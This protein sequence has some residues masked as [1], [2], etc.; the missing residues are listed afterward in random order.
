M[1]ARKLTM[2][3]EMNSEDFADARDEEATGE[4]SE[5]Q[6]KSGLESLA[7]A[8][9]AGLSTSEAAAD[10]DAR[11]S[12]R[13][14]AP[15]RDL[16][17]QPGNHGLPP[18]ASFVYPWPSPS[19][20][21]AR[22][23]PA[24]DRPART[25][26][27]STETSR[28]AILDQYGGG[29]YQSWNPYPHYPPYKAAGPYQSWNPY[30]YDQPYHPA[31]PYLP[32]RSY[33]AP[34]APYPSY[35]TVVEQR[36]RPFGANSQ[37]RRPDL[38][39][40][41]RRPR[42]T[43]ADA[44]R[45][46]DSSPAYYTCDEDDDSDDRRERR[47]HVSFSERSCDG[48]QMD[49]NSRSR[50]A[51]STAK[52]RERPVSSADR[53]LSSTSDASDV[54]DL[55]RQSI[56]NSVAQGNVSTPKPYVKL[57]TYDGT[58]CLETFLAKFDNMANYLKWSDADRLFHLKASLEGSAGQI[59]WD[60]GPQTTFLGVV[61]ILRA[62]FG[63]ELQAERFRAEL[64]ARRRK[65]GETLQNLYQDICKLLA[66]AYPGQSNTAVGIIGRDAFLDALSDP[67]MRV[68]VLEREPK[69]L[70]EALNYASKFEAF[71]RSSGVDRPLSSDSFDGVDRNRSRNVRGIATSGSDQYDVDD[72]RHTVVALQRQ[73]D[74]VQFQQ[75]QMQTTVSNPFY[76]HGSYP[77]DQNIS[78]YAVSQPQTPTSNPNW[79]MG[80]PAKGASKPEN[81]G[82]QMV[83]QVPNKESG[84]GF[85]SR[86]GPKD[87]DHCHRC[88]EVGHWSRDCPRRK[89]TV[90]STTNNSSCNVISGNISPAELYVNAKIG[91]RQILCLFDTGCEHSVVG[92]KLVSTSVFEPSDVKLFAANGTSMPVLGSL[93]L[94]FT[95][96]GH[97]V[98]A[99]LLV[100]DAVEELIIGIDWLSSH[101]CV[102]DFGLG[103]VRLQG[104]EVKL[105]HRKQKPCI[106]RIYVEEECVIHPKH[107]SKIQVRTTWSTLRAPKTDWQFKPRQMSKK[108]VVARRLL[109]GDD[110]HATIRVTNYGNTPFTIRRNRYVGSA[111]PVGA[112]VDTDGSPVS[113]PKTAS[114]TVSDMKTVRR[115][116]AVSSSE[117]VPD[118]ETVSGSETVRGDD[119]VLSSK[120]VR[121]A[122]AVSISR[123]VRD[124]DTGS[125]LQ[126]RS[127]VSVPRTVRDAQTVSGS[128]TARVRR[129]PKLTTPDIESAFSGSAG[130]QEVTAVSIA[131]DS[132]VSPDAQSAS[133]HVPKVALWEKMG[134]G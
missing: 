28:T 121:H 39:T 89:G 130:G 91:N 72:L 123:T 69:T 33:S 79:A 77:H 37:D 106:R 107:H 133:H 58:K 93:R 129:L 75:Q 30:P 40:E 15:R 17:Q 134:V 7:E 104:Y 11:G 86:G 122:D 84:I 35:Y 29:P 94:N 5:M 111:E 90:T 101:G 50:R 8:A 13:L 78:Q 96:E 63:N 116:D 92:R 83:N 56:A 114:N 16:L 18:G 98:T 125:S 87:T 102:W 112:L 44:T 61:Q 88:K 10:S 95:L 51:Y 26:T 100:S 53:E 117:T 80:T 24:A 132:G 67:N 22:S 126:A 41:Q 103:V 54:G 36:H 47:R 127:T 64:R 105:H 76:Y 74:N 9:L 38:H 60:M 59:L 21:A 85:G 70:E 118:A 97:P 25:Q 120:T 14:D 131:V 52:G 71:A 20:A 34:G 109:R 57:A 81:G 49:Y 99:D 6:G 66:F 45:V 55:P 32:D 12:P 108:V 68:K 65:S 19:R 124:V 110:S 42:T 73:L 3:A 4:S 115:A 23:P 119:T 31:G 62:R 113:G 46:R 43:E 2:D 82:K 1:K 128:K 27:T 48:D